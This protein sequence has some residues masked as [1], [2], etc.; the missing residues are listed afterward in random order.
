MSLLSARRTLTVIQEYSLAART[1]ARAHLM[2]ALTIG[3]EC[4]VLGRCRAR[5]LVIA[6]P[7]SVG[8]GTPRSSST[9]EYC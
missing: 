1:R 8:K 9:A 6:R 7:H 3:R 4:V 2:D 5:M